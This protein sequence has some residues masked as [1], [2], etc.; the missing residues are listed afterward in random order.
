M[1]LLP[2][3]YFLHANIFLFFQDLFTAKACLFSWQV[4]GGMWRKLGK[5]KSLPT[6]RTDV[7][8][9]WTKLLI[10]PSMRFW[11]LTDSRWEWAGKKREGGETQ[12]EKKCA[13]LSQSDEKG[14]W[15]F[16]E[17]KKYGFISS[18]RF[19][20][21]IVFVPHEA[22]FSNFEDCKERQSFS[23]PSHLKM[24]TFHLYIV[25]RLW[26]WLSLAFGTVT[27]RGFWQ[28][29][30]ER[31]K[32]STLST[33]KW[34]LPH[35]WEAWCMLMKLGCVC[36]YVCMQACV[37]QVGGGSCIF[38]IP[39]LV[40]KWQK[41]CQEQGGTSKMTPLTKFAPPHPLSWHSE[42]SPRSDLNSKNALLR[43][44][45]KETASQK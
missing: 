28:L 36:M 30:A 41:P 45:K 9:L 4:A 6:I 27:W 18:A 29:P 11:S 43:D 35:P 40:P 17:K 33:F 19:K 24:T 1:A 42:S 20:K 23:P 14:L 3:L 34:S 16:F 37:G 13:T 31:N 10:K 5:K 2:H 26:F 12:G 21:E 22:W 25:F 15:L 44:G 39:P 32:P 38:D 8:C 7:G